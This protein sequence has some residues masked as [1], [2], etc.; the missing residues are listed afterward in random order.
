MRRTLCQEQLAAAAGYQ[1]ES[2][3]ELPLL[4]YVLVVRPED[5]AHLT[6]NV[7]A[8]PFWAWPGTGHRY[9]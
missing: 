3:G 7:P 1:V 8:M 4:R 2:S 6:V 9:W 5:R